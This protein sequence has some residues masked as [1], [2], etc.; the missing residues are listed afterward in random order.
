MPG[1]FKIFIMAF[2]PGLPYLVIIFSYV[3]ILKK[4]KKSRNKI[5]EHSMSCRNSLT[6]RDRRM[7]KMMETSF[8]E[9]RKIIYEKG[10]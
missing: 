6:E 10:V 8:F 9:K 7:S 5:L 3:M 4:Y 2:G 1:S